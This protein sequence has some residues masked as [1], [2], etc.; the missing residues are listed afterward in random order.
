MRTWVDASTIIALDLAGETEILRTLL[1]RVSLTQELAEEVF[2]GRESRALREAVGSWIDVLD[3][4]G[5]RRRWMNLGLGRGEASLFLTPTGDRLVLD[6]LPARTVAESEGRQYV[7]LL[8]LLGAGVHTGTL[9]RSRGIE[10]IRKVVAAG[11]HL[12]SHL[13]DAFLADLEGD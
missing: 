3:V 7:G 5:D 10:I 9:G 12:A 1:G 6:E 4:K 8:G 11:F 2:T 13:Y